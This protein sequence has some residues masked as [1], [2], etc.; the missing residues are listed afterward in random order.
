[1]IFKVVSVAAAFI[2]IAAIVSFICIS[3]RQMDMQR[4]RM[5]VSLFVGLRRRDLLG[6]EDC[7]VG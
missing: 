6:G 4:S 2:S 5:Q 7:G 3:V 1:M